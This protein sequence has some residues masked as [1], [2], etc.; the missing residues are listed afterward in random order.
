MTCY[1]KLWGRLSSFR[2]FIIKIHSRQVPRLQEQ[3][4]GIL[5]AD[6]KTKADCQGQ[7]LFKH[8]AQSILF[9]D[10]LGKWPHFILSME[11]EEDVWPTA[12]LSLLNKQDSSQMVTKNQLLYVNE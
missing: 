10:E 8:I 5:L 1:V 12:S 6:I 9:Q 11:E 2:D 3:N 4:S 7:G